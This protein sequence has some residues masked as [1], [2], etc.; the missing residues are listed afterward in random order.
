LG[1][2][3][4]DEREKYMRVR[5]IEARKNWEKIPIADRRACY[6]LV[7]D[8]RVKAKALLND[9]LWV[10]AT[11]KRYLSYGIDSI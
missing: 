1:K 4:R 2:M 11:E 6:R 10:E 9:P 3:S 7:A 8:A 5:E